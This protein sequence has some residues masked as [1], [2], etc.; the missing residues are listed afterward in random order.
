MKVKDVMT[1]KPITLRQTDTLDKVLKTLATHDISGCPVVDGQKR[2]VGIVGQT[3]VIKFIDV[4]SKINKDEDFASFI[5]SLIGEKKLD[6]K[7]LKSKK[8]RDFLK[9]GAITIGHNSSVYDA[10]RLMNRHD[11]ERLPV[12]QNK[13]LV[14]IITRKDVIKTLEKMEKS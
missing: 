13:R 3:D 5:N 14:G 2:V 12:V 11:V 1:K 4:Y 8:V 10:A 9:K 6:V 7:K